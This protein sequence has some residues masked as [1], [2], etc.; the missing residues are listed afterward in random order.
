MANFVS[1][2][3][4]AASHRHQVTFKV[5]NAE[6]FIRSSVLFGGKFLSSQLFLSFSRGNFAD[7]LTLGLFVKI[8]LETLIRHRNSDTLRRVSLRSTC[9]KGAGH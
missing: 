8:A 4:S 1:T 7:Y 2:F 9:S 5:E 6:G 3:Q